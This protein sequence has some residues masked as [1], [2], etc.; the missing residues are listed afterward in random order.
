M[1]DLFEVFDLEKNLKVVDEEYY[2]SKNISKEER[3]P[4]TITNI[5][6]YYY[7]GEDENDVRSV[8]DFLNQFQNDALCIAEIN[9]RETNRDNLSDEDDLE[10][11]EEKGFVEYNYFQTYLLKYNDDY[12]V[13][14]KPYLMDNDENVLMLQKASNPIDAKIKF[15]EMSKGLEEKGFNVSLIKDTDIL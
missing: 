5:R 6:N 11:L 3:M 10:E 1:K 4:S 14:S 9:K 8:I 2:D 13:L 15:T 7:A 12:Y